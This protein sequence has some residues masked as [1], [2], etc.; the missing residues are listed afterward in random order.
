MVTNDHRDRRRCLIAILV[1]VALGCIL[2][3]SWQ[4]HRWPNEFATG[5]M[6]GTLY[7]QAAAAAVWVALGPPPLLRRGLVILAWLVGMSIALVVTIVRFRSGMSI[8]DLVLLFG[9]F[10]GQWFLV[11]LPLWGG[12]WWRGLRLEMDSGQSAGRHALGPPQFTIRH[13]MLLTAVVAV[14]LAAARLAITRIHWQA[15]VP[16]AVAHEGPIFAYVVLVSVVLTLPLAVAAL[17]PQRAAL[18]IAVALAFAAVATA[19]EVEAAWLVAPGPGDMAGVVVVF[20]TMNGAQAGWVLGILLL[21]RRAGYRLASSR[22][23]Q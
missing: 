21:L 7:G 20:W 2:V 3:A 12:R 15:T 4:P 18:A 22:L 14:V 16:N 9:S 23:P 8:G 1:A 11:Q 13:V 17:V 6:L 10:L 19:A 5:I